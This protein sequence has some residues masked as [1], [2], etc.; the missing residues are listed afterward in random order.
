MFEALKPQPA[1]KILALMQMYRDDPRAEKIDLGVGVYTDENGKLPLLACVKEAENLLAETPKPRGYLPIDGIPAYDQAV[2]SLV[3]GAGSA[4]LKAGRVVAAQALGRT[5]GLKLGAD[6][7]KRLRP[8]ARVELLDGQVVEM[9]PIGSPP[10]R[11]GAPPQPVPT[12]APRR[13]PRPLRRRPGRP[14]RATARSVGPPVRGSPGWSARPTSGS[15]GTARPA[16]DRP[17][18]TGARSASRTASPARYSPPRRC[19]AG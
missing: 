15:T 4:V 18:G 13:S 10:A 5:G 17:A 8:D 6:F 3:F 9:S 12:P 2:Q 19:C 11:S 16:S 14:A 7:L 1:D